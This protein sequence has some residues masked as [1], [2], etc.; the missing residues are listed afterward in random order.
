MPPPSG[1]G[2]LER[3]FLQLHAAL[4]R[5][6]IM[7]GHADFGDVVADGGAV[8]FEH[9]ALEHGARLLEQRDQVIVRHSPLPLGMMGW[10]NTTIG[11]YGLPYLVSRKRLELRHVVYCESVAR[12]TGFEPATC[13]FGGCHSIQLS[14]GRVGAGDHTRQRPE[15]LFT[16][17]AAVR[18]YFAPPLGASGSG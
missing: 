2:P 3:G 15:R 6:L 9:V 4:N 14:Y 18:L 5:Q 17:Q 10:K 16:R 1:R 13:S 12:P 8:C 7:D 11:G